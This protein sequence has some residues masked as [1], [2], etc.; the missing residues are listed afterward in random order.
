MSIVSITRVVDDP[1]GQKPLIFERI[2]PGNEDIF[3]RYV[4]GYCPYRG[5]ARLFEAY[6]P[7]STKNHRVWKS[8]QHYKAETNWAHGTKYP[9]LLTADMGDSNSLLDIHFMRDERLFN[10]GLELYKQAIKWSYPL[11]EWYVPQA[12][13][14]FI[15]LPAN[16][17]SLKLY[18]LRTMVPQIKSELSSLVSLYELK[19]MLSIRGTIRNLAKLGKSLFSR[20]GGSSTRPIGKALVRGGADSF[21]QW[22]FNLSPLISDI[23]GIYRIVSTYERRI[24]DLINRSGKTQISRF[25][26]DLKEQLKPVELN[27]GTNYFPGALPQG[28]ILVGP[29]WKKFK[30]YFNPRRKV[31]PLFAEFR[32]EMQYNYTFTAFQLEHAKVLGLLDAFGVTFN[33]A[34]I[35]N[36]I[37]WSFVID[38]VVN[39]SS[40]L[41]Q[42]EIKNLAP[43]VNILQYCWSIKKKRIISYSARLRTQRYY[44][45]SYYAWQYFTYPEVTE[46]SYR[47][48]IDLPSTSSFT[49]SGLSPTEL[50]LGAALLVTRRRRKSRSRRNA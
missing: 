30:A 50:S 6:T 21:L 23:T 10:Y 40:W 36:V 44:Y 38:W 29:V 26:C 33:P 11:E 27:W 41:D 24:N 3:P 1:P 25:K 46:T 2:Q 43:K 31:V 12:D 18:G 15:P 17:E 4:T 49:T 42:F 39:V 48:G 47:R 19:D 9:L 34:H 13:G 45:G 14:G 22:K 8:F 32:S 37:P 16:L 5:T 28:E 35:W 7:N 20:I